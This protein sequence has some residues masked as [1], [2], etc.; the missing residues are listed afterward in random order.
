MTKEIREMAEQSPENYWEQLERIERLNKASELKA[1]VIF[2]FHSFILG[3]LV[4]HMDILTP[5]F[6]EYIFFIMIFSVWLLLVL[7]SIYFCF[8]CFTPRLELKFKKSIFFFRDAAHAYGD[9]SDY[10]ETY[11]NVCGD[12]KQLYQQLSQQI[13]I[14]SV[15]VDKKFASVQRS[16]RFFALSFA[17]VLVLIISWAIIV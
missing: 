2:S 11:T 8:R 10:T 3:F 6:N 1:G 4:D 12:P 13:Y 14:E 15:V 16:L 17:A 7:V 5:L 9:V